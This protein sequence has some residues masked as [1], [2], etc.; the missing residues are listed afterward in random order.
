MALAW[1]RR[2]GAAWRG[3]AFDVVYLYREAALI[4]GPWL[5]V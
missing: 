2:V 5:G 4:G 3:G 1:L